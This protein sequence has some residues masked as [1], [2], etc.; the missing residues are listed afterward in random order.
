MIEYLK[1]KS[2]SLAAESRIIRK[3]ERHTLANARALSGIYDYRHKKDE[4]RPEMPKKT[5]RA[6]ILEGADAKAREAYDL[7]WGLTH[8]RKN[9]VRKEARDTHIALHFLKGKPYDTVEDFAYS[10]PNWDNIERMVLQYS[11]G[12]SPQ[13][14]KQRFEEW[15]QN[16]EAWIGEPLFSL[17]NPSN[18]MRQEMVAKTRTVPPKKK[19]A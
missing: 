4:P 11:E 15:V 5:E 9:V 8:H 14:I 6:S 17:R 10:Q 2:A 16:A 19:V 3:R 13:D 1:V 18:R 12:E 7:F